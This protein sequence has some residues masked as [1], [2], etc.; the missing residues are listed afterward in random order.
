MVGLDDIISQGADR[1]PG[2]RRRSRLLLAA[3]VVLVAALII[4][5]HLPHQSRHSRPRP[6]AASGQSA[7]VQPATAGA[8]GPAMF[9]PN[10]RLPRAGAR[11]S[12]FW[13]ATGHEL[14]IGGLPP[15]HAGYAFTE[16]L[17]GW[18]IQLAQPVGAASGCR[19]CTRAPS[20]VYYLAGRG[21]A[22]T[23]VGTA[24]QVG[25]AATAGALW[26]VSYPDNVSLGT[27]EGTARE[28]TGTGARIGSALRLPAGY[29]ID[30]ATS[31]GLLLAPLV[32]G[33][34]KFLL[35]SSRGRAR[36]FA[37]VIAASAST[38]AWVPRCVVTCPVQVLTLATG[39]Q[40]AITPSPGSTVV[41]A[42][43]SRDGRY[44]ALGLSTGFGDQSGELTMRLEVA[45]VATG[46]LAL[47]PQSWLG[48][49]AA[50]ARFG[51]W[52]GHDEL[53]TLRR[54]M[55]KVQLA[56]WRPGASSLAVVTIMTRPG[57]AELV[58]G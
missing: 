4:S 5:E 46:S 12:W 15:D 29:G 38:I 11:P 17:G 1:G 26:L 30:Q 35:W 28:V 13:P 54:L 32:A 48:S 9:G 3:A 27:A 43:F 22:V 55:A 41:D 8:T 6:V 56:C 19:Q 24:D 57:R 49:A 21:R 45:T 51:W 18:A 14:S 25:S 42:K 37:D 33:A 16:L 52:A 2:R 50:L 40:V 34:R 53:L 7:P 44:L 20:A 23:R 58:L 47:L 36:A 10:L 31:R 39:R